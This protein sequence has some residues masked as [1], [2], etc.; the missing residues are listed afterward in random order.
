MGGGAGEEQRC[1]LCLLLGCSRQ[2]G[3]GSWQLADNWKIAV[4]RVMA[5][6][7]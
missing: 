1:V 3:D 6:G 7:C 2:L 5:V 4:G